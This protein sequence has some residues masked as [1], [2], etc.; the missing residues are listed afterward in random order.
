MLD[1][2]CRQRSADCE[3]RWGR[4]VIVLCWIYRDDSAAP[5]VNIDGVVESLFLCRIVRDSA[6]PI[7]K[8]DGVVESFILCRIVR[9]SSAPIV[10]LDGVVESLFCAGSSVTAA[11][12]L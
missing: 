10:N 12:R 7:V 4:R 9:D 8:L 2:P 3:P 5:I 6:A 1:L 11:R